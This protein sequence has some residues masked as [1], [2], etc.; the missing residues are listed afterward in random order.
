MN[1][2]VVQQVKS[3]FNSLPNKDLDKL[4]NLLVAAG[5]TKTQKQVGYKCVECTIMFKGT[6]ASGFGRDELEAVHICLKNFIEQMLEEEGHLVFLRNIL[7]ELKQL[8]FQ[9]Q[10]IEQLQ[11]KIGNISIIQNNQNYQTVDSLLNGENDQILGQI[12][13]N[14]SKKFETLQDNKENIQNQYQKCCSHEQE[15]KKEKMRVEHLEL[16]IKLILEENRILKSLLN[17]KKESARQESN[18]EGDTKRIRQQVRSNSVKMSKMQQVNGVP[19]L[20]LDALPTYI[21]K[22]KALF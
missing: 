10:D 20:N 8:D 17:E 7:K 22:Q 13:D 12:V 5:I 1:K 3:I 14:K 16:R 15:L 18:R 9:E 19:K 6:N 4:L 11:Q 2:L 21:G